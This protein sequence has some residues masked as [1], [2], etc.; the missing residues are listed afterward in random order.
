MKK[1][2]VLG[3]GL[4]GGVI[5]KDLAA[6]GHDV[7]VADIDTK[8]VAEK[9]KGYPG[10]KVV[11]ADFANPEDIKK[12]IED[13]DVVVGAVPGFLAKAMLETVI[14]AGKKISDI[15]F[16]PENP[17]EFDDLVKE[18]GQ[19]TLV[20]IGVAPGMSHILVGYVDSLLDQ[21]NNIT[22]YVGG[23]PVIRQWP[24]EYKAVFSPIDV[25]EEYIRPAR[26]KEHGKV[27]EKP[28][29]SDI[30]LIN[31]PGTDTL[32]AFFT[33]GLRTLLYTLD[34]PEMKEK[35][36]RFPGHAEL[37]KVFRETGFF[38]DDPVLVKG[39]EV[40]P[41]DLV[42]KLLFPAW[43]LKE[44]EKDFTVLRVQVE[45]IK[46]GKNYRY[47]YDML[48]SFDDKRNETSMARTTG[49]PCS[50]MA[51][52]IAEG[53]FSYTEGVC[54]PEYIGKNHQAFKKLM[55]KLEKKGI[56]FNATVEE[57]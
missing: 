5:A 46:D 24:Y 49:Y 39:M 43:K 52:L 47:T 28:A 20:D 36:L 13:A 44:G 33:D 4:V 22:I 41:R 40:K 35:T 56:V 1:F 10:A 19:T 48:D 15:S 8:A 53:E 21:T 26:F 31:L 9:L 50:I 6:E 23:L 7:L 38:S 34:A 18:Y 29:L 3:G 42:A 14:K 57:I 17:L 25:T 11:K 16:M 55:D 30:E 45:G 2:T 12:V 54:A 32:E 27:V 37:M 51:Q